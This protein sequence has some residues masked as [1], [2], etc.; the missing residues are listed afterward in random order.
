MGVKEPGRGGRGKPK[1]EVKH[2]L[3]YI[4]SRPWDC[5]RERGEDR[6]RKEIGKENKK[7]ER[8]GYH[9]KKSQKA[10]EKWGKAEN[11]PLDEQTAEREMR[12]P[13]LKGEVIYHKGCKS[14]LNPNQSHRIVV[15][16]QNTFLGFLLIR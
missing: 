14:G 11:H 9:R 4:V 2:E 12:F 13:W 5:G 16:G 1:E 6:R 7:E 8:G 10:D 3:T 15:P